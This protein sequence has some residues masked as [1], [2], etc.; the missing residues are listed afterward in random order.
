MILSYLSII[1]I[2]I[3]NNMNR[4]V[5]PIYYFVNNANKILAILLAISMFMLF[6]N[7]DI[8]YN[9]IINTISLSTFGVLQIHANSDAM[10]YFIWSI[11]F[12]V[13]EQYYPKSL[14]IHAIL[15]VII[16]YIVCTSIELLRIKYLEKQII[17]FM[18][19][20][21]NYK[22]ICLKINSIMNADEQIFYEEPKKLIL[23]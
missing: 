19:N 13:S 22:K 23:K 2:D 5:L 1:V 20:K 10:R 15:T 4:H 16:I 9:K 11:C 17:K 21:F 14:I 12:K 3:F 7:I 6:K 18:R 8:K